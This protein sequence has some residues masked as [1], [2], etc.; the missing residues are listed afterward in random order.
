MDIYKCKHCDEAWDKIFEG[1]TCEEE[2]CACEDMIQLEEKTAD[3]KNEKHVPFVEKTDNGIKVTV[4]SAALHPMV[5]DHWI[6]MIEV[7]DGSMVY[8]KYLNPGDKPEAEFPT[9]NL[10]VKA[11]EYCNKHGLWANK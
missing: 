2:G 4:G 11:R 10:N 7:I 1:T 8:R 9:N 6:T 5:A 3:F